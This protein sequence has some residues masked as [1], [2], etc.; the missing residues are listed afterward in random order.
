MKEAHY[1]YERWGATAKVKD[2]ETRY[3]HLFPQSSGMAHMPTH[4]TSGTTSSRSDTTFDLAT[5]L[6][7]SQAIYREIELDQ[8]LTSLMKI[9]IENAGAQTGFLILENAGE[10]VIEASGELN[11]GDGENV[12]TTQVLQSIPT[13]NHLPESIINYVIRTHEAVIL[14]DATREGNFINEPYIQHNQSQSILCLP[15]LNQGKLV[16]VL[17]LENQLAAGAFT[18]DRSQVLHLL[19]TQAAI[20]LE[21]A[22]LYSK[23]RASESQ[24]AQFLEAVPVAIAVLDAAGRPYYANQR[25]IQLVGKGIDPSVAPDQFAEVYQF[26]LAGTEQKY[27]T[28]KLPI[29]RALSGERTTVDDMEIRQNNAT[30]PVEAW[31]TPVFDEQGNVA[32]A[33]VAFQDITERKQAEKFLENYNQTLQQQILER[34]QEL[35]QALEYLKATQKELIHSEKMAALGKLIAGVAH[36]INTPLGVINS[37]ANNISRFLSQA[38]REFPILFQTLS[39]EEQQQF[40]KLLQRSLQTQLS[41]SAR[42]ERQVKS[43]LT[44]QL[45]ASEIENADMLADLLVDMRVY[46][47]LDAFLPLLKRANGFDVL[48]IAYKLS[49]LQRGIQTISTATER[50]SKV[51]FALK[52][53]ARYD[54]SGKMVPAIVTEG[55]ETAITL[56]HNQIKHGVEVVKNYAEMP[57]ICCYP[58]E[59]NQVWTNLIHNALQAMDNRGILTIDTALLE[60]QVKIGVTDTGKGIPVDIQSKIFDAFFTTKS[61]GEGSGLGLHI[62]KR[63]IEKHSG[64]IS[65]ASQPGRTTFQVLLP[66]ESPEETHADVVIEDLEGCRHTMKQKKVNRNDAGESRQNWAY[67]SVCR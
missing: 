14:N 42:E 47:N 49:G 60:R 46:D 41:L 17:Y 1:C 48:E 65:V 59:L 28:E 20:A 18:P 33:I 10:W 37:S 27:P 25:R 6:K 2:L 11:A 34:T 43:A 26:Y 23:L 61:M 22:K 62:V 19:S 29:I 39:T 5:V 44:Q 54:S 66:I 3:P 15:L 21:N 12:Y 13:A 45:E 67:F 52:T 53:Y 50:T 56:Y 40:L 8:L 32:Y 57:P 16:S 38:L 63:I 4:K 64:Q 7:A 55:I 30:I 51:V 9:L 31:G 58:D 35:S 36:E 24:M